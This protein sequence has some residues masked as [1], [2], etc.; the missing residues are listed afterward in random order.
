M[1]SSRC[2]FG[3]GLESRG[4]HRCP[5]PASASPDAADLLSDA[6]RRPRPGGVLSFPQER[7]AELCAV[8][9]EDTA[10]VRRQQPAVRLGCDARPG[11]FDQAALLKAFQDI[12][13]SACRRRSLSLSASSISRLL[14]PGVE[15]IT[16]SVR[17]TRGCGRIGTT[18]ACERGRI[19]GCCRARSAFAQPRAEIRLNDEAHQRR[20]QLH[21]PPAVGLA[22]PRADHRQD[23]HHQ[24]LGDQ[25]RRRRQL[26]ANDDLAARRVQHLAQA[27][28]PRVARPRLEAAHREAAQRAAGSPS[29]AAHP[30]TPG[31]PTG[32]QRS[33]RANTPRGAAASAT[34]PESRSRTSANAGGMP[35][36]TVSGAPAN[37]PAGSQLEATPVSIRRGLL[38]DHG[39]TLTSQ[40]RTN[41]QPMRRVL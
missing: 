2:G 26:A 31:A 33:G 37:D 14:N 18:S 32:P 13:E 10:A 20:R 4:G 29:A 19:P 17:M 15:A 30:G 12:R 7:C 39:S 21:Q 3:E 27:R 1:L 9:L 5:P 36:P 35:S 38:A 25:G 22:Q 34:V 11:V 8:Q 40:T 16:P 28:R 23:R 24:Q 41:G 6:P